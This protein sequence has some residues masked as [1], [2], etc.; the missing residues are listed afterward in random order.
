MLA[1]AV[2]G[3]RRV[4]ARLQETLAQLADK[5]P[6]D[7]D[8]LEALDRF[9]RVETDALLMQFMNMVAIVQDQ[10]VRSI[11]FA[12][13]EE[14]EGRTRIDHRN[15]AEKLGAWPPGL[16]FATVVRAR[17][18]LAHQYPHDPAKQASLIN[19]VAAATPIAL[20]AFRGM[21]DYVARR[22]PELRR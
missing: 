10:L 9:G 2:E 15:A 12:A 8:G 11:L 14:V 5:L 1:D 6:F 20:A 18:S 7:A 4:S 17:N 19:E 22:Y 13:D 3:G 21:A 16:D